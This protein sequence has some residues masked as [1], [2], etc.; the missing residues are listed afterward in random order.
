MKDYNGFSGAE[1]NK[2]DYIQ[3]KAIAKGEL[4]VEQKCCMCGQTEGL[5]M[6]HMENYSNPLDLNAIIP[7]C[8]ECHL[9]LHS[10]F[11][12]PVMWIKHCLAVRAGYVS[13]PYDKVRFFNE[14]NEG[15]TIESLGFMPDESKWWECLSLQ[16][17]DLKNTLYNEI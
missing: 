7:M 4:V 5:I 3:K 16:E 14:K 1:R 10:R 11:S 2:A 8:V 13:T 12:K 6:R 9:K 15:E 17:Q